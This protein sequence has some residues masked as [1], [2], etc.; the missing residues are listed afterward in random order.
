MKKVL[1]LVLAFAFCLVLLNF[2]PVHGEEAVYENV[3]RLHVVANSDSDADQELKLKVRDALLEEM[4]GILETSATRA[5]ALEKIEQN[6]DFIR[7]IAEKIVAENGFDY[8]VSVSL[9]RERYPT[10][11]YEGVC[12]P[13]GVYESLQVKIGEAKGK[14]WWCVLFPRLCLAPAS[15]K[16]AE[17]A[18][19]QVGLT[20]EQYRIITET[21]DTK[22]KLRF[23]FL[24]LFN[25]G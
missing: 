18:F 4:P 12:F 10:K 6:L 3:V 15:K 20:S 22:Y 8:P 21:E 25:V 14:N 2:L 19:V 9:G 5:D 11:N 17:D 24:E 13:S 23:K 7:E 1:I 16:S